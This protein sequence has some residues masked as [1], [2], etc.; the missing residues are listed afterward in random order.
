MKT[1]P[2]K[3]HILLID[4]DPDDV[5]LTSGVLQNKIAH[6][7]ITIARTAEEGLI[8]AGQQDWTMI[9]LDHK[10]PGKN[11]MEVLPEIRLLAPDAGIVMLTGH[12]DTEIAIAALRAGADYYLKKSA[13]MAL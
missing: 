8:L 9:F 1:E 10:L 3:E 7:S 11:G 6:G 5:E 12:E 4:D 13:N 2:H